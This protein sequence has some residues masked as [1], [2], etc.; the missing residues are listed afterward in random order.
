[1]MS[2]PGQ[3]ELPFAP[4]QRPRDSDSPPVEV[5]EEASWPSVA[6]GLVLIAVAGTGAVTAMNAE[7]VRLLG[8]PAPHQFG[9][10]MKQFI[11]PRYHR[12]VDAWSERSDGDA[13]AAHPD[14]L[15]LSL[16]ALRPDGS[17]VR[18]L[19]SRRMLGSQGDAAFLVSV[20]VVP[21]PQWPV[22]DAAPRHVRTHRHPSSP[23][24][25]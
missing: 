1:M 17:E 3:P 14:R 25:G 19:M 9:L 24:E 8:P 5:V 21:E 18:V 6:S 22:S 4:P 12:V 16:S 7:A 20:Q 15:T 10:G 2:E 13:R 23:V 11:P